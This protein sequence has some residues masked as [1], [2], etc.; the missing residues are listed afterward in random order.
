MRAIAIEE[1]VEAEHFGAILAFMEKL[2]I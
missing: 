2:G 1:E